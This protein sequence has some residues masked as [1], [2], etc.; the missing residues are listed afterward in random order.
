MVALA[1]ALPACGTLPDDGRTKFADSLV[2]VW[3]PLVGQRV[4]EVMLWATPSHLASPSL[5]FEVR[6]D[7]SFVVESVGDDYV[8]LR[9]GELRWWIPL[10][11]LQL[12]AARP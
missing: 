8:L 2:G 3:R 6:P 12:R 9:N 7:G 5:C 4:A 1:L 10:G 11:V